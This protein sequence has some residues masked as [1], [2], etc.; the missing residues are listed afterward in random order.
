M[1][2]LNTE[3]GMFDKTSIRNTSAVLFGVAS[4]ALPSVGGAAGIA[5]KASK[6]VVVKKY[7]GASAEADRWGSVQVI[8]TSRTTIASGSK[9]VTRKYT[10]LG[11]S[12]T[13]HTSR[14]QYIMSQALPRLRQEFLTAQS[15]NVQMVSGATY[16]SEAFIQSLQSALLKA[17]A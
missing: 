12:Y 16:T 13:Y 3:R 14:S 17:R 10:D 1:I 15:A 8:V 7:T 5:T 2:D 11:G 4:L 9:K 6:R